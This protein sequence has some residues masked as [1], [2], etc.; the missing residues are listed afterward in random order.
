MLLCHYALADATRVYKPIM[1]DLNIFKLRKL[2][3]NSHADC[4][5]FGHDHF[6]YQLND[7]PIFISPGSLGFK[8]GSFIG[9][10]VL[11]VEQPISYEVVILRYNK[12]RYDNDLANSDF[13]KKDYV[14]Y[15]HPQHAT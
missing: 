15:M 2:F 1:R 8:P 10:C 5:L 9:Y 6:G 14:T 3:Q 13:P 11:T 7:A 12:D 4:I